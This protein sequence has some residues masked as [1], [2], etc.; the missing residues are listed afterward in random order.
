[1]WLRLGES[2]CLKTLP[3]C[4]LIRSTN[5]VCSKSLPGFITIRIAL[6]TLDPLDTDGP[7]FSASAR[8][9]FQGRLLSFNHP[10]TQHI[11][12]LITKVIN[13]ANAVVPTGDKPLL[14]IAPRHHKTRIYVLYAAAAE[15]RLRLALVS[16]HRAPSREA[17]QTVHHHV[18]IANIPWTRAPF[19]R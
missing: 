17:S 11:D 1:M 6:P 9:P 2:G 19:K 7:T 3:C 15:L 18:A 14:G 4:K 8:I 5:S 16:G 13:A 12:D 10:L